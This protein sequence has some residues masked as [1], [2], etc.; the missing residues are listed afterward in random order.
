MHDAV[1]AKCL[2]L[3]G[4]SIELPFVAPVAKHR[5]A[6]ERV[7]WAATFTHVTVTRSHLSNLVVGPLVRWTSSFVQHSTM[8]KT[9]KLLTQV[10]V[11]TICVV[12]HGICHG[13]CLGVCHGT[14]IFDAIARLEVWQWRYL[15]QPQVLSFQPPIHLSR[16]PFWSAIHVH[17]WLYTLHCY[18]VPF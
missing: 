10:G 5:F 8:H 15:T 18:H 13:I 9:C 3:G 17:A 1:H 4:H 2:P 6:R 14:G 12:R 16:P 11:A 7:H